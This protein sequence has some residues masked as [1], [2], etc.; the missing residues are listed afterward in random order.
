MKAISRLQTRRGL[1]QSGFSLLDNKE[2]SLA[3]FPG[4]TLPAITRK[5]PAYLR[6]GTLAPS[7]GPHSISRP[8]G[9][10]RQQS[11]LTGA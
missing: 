7:D 9:G 4:L 10:V 11:T 2:K 1:V 6:N 8:Q 3:A 5:W